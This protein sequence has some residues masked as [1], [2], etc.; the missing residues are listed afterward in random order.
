MWIFE[1]CV[2]HMSAAD[3][4]LFFFRNQRQRRV[5]GRDTYICA[6]PDPSKFGT[7]FAPTC[8]WIFEKCA[9]HMSAADSQLFFLQK[10]EP[11]ACKA[12]TLTL[13]TEKC[14][15]LFFA[16]ICLWITITKVEFFCSKAFPAGILS[17]STKPVHCI[18]FCINH[19][20][21]HEQ[22]SIV[23]IRSEKKMKQFFKN[24]RGKGTTFVTD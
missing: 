12:R 22:F 7:N 19:F 18:F 2:S 8:C 17:N 13:L 14:I 6:T 24:F 5:Q 21:L 9:P 3:S 20:A 15:A 16:T 11:K 10:S 1:R 4:Q 23:K